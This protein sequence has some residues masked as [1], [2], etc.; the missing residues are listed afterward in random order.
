MVAIKLKSTL[1]DNVL[2]FLISDNVTTQHNLM[3]ILMG[4]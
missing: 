4:D 1:S 2:E 3:G